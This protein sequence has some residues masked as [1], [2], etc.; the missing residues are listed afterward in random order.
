VDSRVA[1]YTGAYF[2]Y[3]FSES[4][5][6][7]DQCGLVWCLV[8]VPKPLI[9]KRFEDALKEHCADPVGQKGDRV[10]HVLL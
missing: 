7:V 3:S 1:I 6:V 8:Q 9:R 2:G 10:N 5:R 4:A